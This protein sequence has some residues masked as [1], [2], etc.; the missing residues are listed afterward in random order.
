[1]HE[2]NQNAQMCTLHYPA[3]NIS[4]CWV[5]I[6][7]WPLILNLVQIEA[8]LKINLVLEWLLV[9]VRE[10]LDQPLS[11]LAKME[12]GGFSGQISP[13]SDFHGA[14]FD[15][16]N[17]LLASLLETSQY[18]GKTKVNLKSLSDYTIDQ[19]LPSHLQIQACPSCFYSET[20]LLAPM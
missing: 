6:S 8:A 18:I 1:M 13:N 19:S 17:Q 20:N 2:G 12:N 4:R 10:S 14:A 11:S 7:L 5:C 9:T 15:S 16:R 3:E